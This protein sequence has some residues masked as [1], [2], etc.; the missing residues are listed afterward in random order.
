VP[1]LDQTLIVEPD[2]GNPPLLCRPHQRHGAGPQCAP[3]GKPDE[4]IP[5]GGKVEA[6]WD[7]T[8]GSELSREQGVQ[9]S[10]A[11]PTS[12]NSYLLLLVLIDDP[13]VARRPV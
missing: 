8:F 13:I 1:E 3:L 6:I 12:L 5:L 11:E 10:Q 7:R 9:E 4:L 2:P